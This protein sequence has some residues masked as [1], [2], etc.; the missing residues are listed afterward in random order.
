MLKKHR[1]GDLLG[2]RAEGNV[3][4]PEHPLITTGARPLQQSSRNIPRLRAW[5]VDRWLGVQCVQSVEVRQ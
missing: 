1:P 5:K 4:L 2:H 3:F